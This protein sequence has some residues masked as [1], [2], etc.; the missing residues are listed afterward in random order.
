MDPE[1]NEAGTRC[2]PMEDIELLVTHAGKNYE[3]SAVC[4]KSAFIITHK[5]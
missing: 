1:Q 2:C 5:I 4:Q 3:D